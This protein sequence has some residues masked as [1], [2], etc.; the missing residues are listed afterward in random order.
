MWR[1]I[2]RIDS[3]PNSS[4]FWDIWFSNNT[5]QFRF[6]LSFNLFRNCIAIH[7]ASYIRKHFSN[8][9]QTRNKRFK[10]F[11]H[12][13]ALEIGSWSQL[14][15]DWLD[16]KGCTCQKGGRTTFIKSTFSNLPIYFFFFHC[17]LIESS[18][19]SELSC[20]E[21]LER[22]LSSSCSCGIRFAHQ[23]E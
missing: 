5:Y 15:G 18:R 12:T 22:R 10:I 13:W 14:R 16:G 21:E 20:R 17:W 8:F 19:F 9:Y 2:Y 23:V 3:W 7:T 6:S 11:P 4:S 1:F